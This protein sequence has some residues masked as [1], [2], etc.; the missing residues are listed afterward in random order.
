LGTITMGG[1]A[2]PGFEVDEQGFVKATNF[3]EKVVVVNTGNRDQYFE[4]ISTTKVRL[5]FDG[6]LGGDVT[7]N[8]QL[9]TAPFNTTATAIKPIGDIK[10]P[11]Q[12]ADDYATVNIIINTTGVEFTSGGGGSNTIAQNVSSQTKIP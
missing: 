10:L 12:A 9:D 7:M 3:A 11:Q 1:S 8:M 2:N 6:S 5:V 4:P